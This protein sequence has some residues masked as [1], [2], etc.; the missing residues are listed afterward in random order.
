M[1]SDHNPSHFALRSLR[2]IAATTFMVTVMS[3]CPLYALGEASPMLVTGSGVLAGDGFGQALAVDGDWM[4]VGAPWHD[5]VGTDAGGVWVFQRQGQAWQEFGSLLPAAGSTRA[6]FGVSVAVSDGSLAVGAWGDSA[7]GSESGAVYTYAWD[8]STWASQG[9][10]RPNVPLAQER[11]GTSVSLSGD[12][13]AVGAY[14]ASDQ[15]PS[16]GA[17]Y[18]FACDGG[19]WQEQIRLASPTGVKG[20]YFGRSVAIDGG[21]LAVG[22]YGQDSPTAVNAGA[23]HVYAQDGG[24]WSATP[25]ASFVG[26]AAGD[27]LG[28]AV[29]VDGDT[30]LVSAPKAGVGGVAQVYEHDAGVWSLQSVLT[31]PAPVEGDLF[32]ES[33]AL[34][35][36]DAIIGDPGR[37]P[38]GAAYAFTRASGAWQEAGTFAAGTSPDEQLA[39][40]AVAIQDGL[41]VAGAPGKSSGLFSGAVYAFAAGTKTAW[42]GPPGTASPWSNANNWSAGVPSSA[43][44][45]AVAGPDAD[46]EASA[47][48]ITAGVLAIGMSGQAQLKL[49][50]AQAE[51]GQLRIGP[52]GVVCA[53]A[54]STITLSGGLSNAGSS[55]NSLDIS[56]ATVCWNAPGQQHATLEV[57]GQ[58]LG[59][60]EAGW[61]ENASIGHLII[62][63]DSLLNLTD[64]FDNARGASPEALYIGELTIEPGGRIALA[65]LNLYYRNGGVPLRLVP[66]DSD[67]DGDVDW[68]DLQTLATNFGLQGGGW[69]AGDYDG[70]GVVGASDYMAVKLHM[71]TTQPVQSNLVPEPETFILLAALVMAGGVVRR[72][73]PRHGGIRIGVTHKS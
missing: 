17:A 11:F 8:G 37:G 60:D 58:D 38:N 48:S 25:A 30:L 10:L 62:S 12:R 43:T 33:V 16:S 63:A 26:S 56:A 52:G 65:G 3:A 55:P 7:G 49:Q 34:D 40:S 64:L 13:L 72:N 69:Q 21:V 42:Q 45:A 29:A 35:G 6:G 70:D 27:E 9:V 32:G 22:A 61:A 23:V 41:A 18:V 73:R 67:L 59:P 71:G 50:D 1:G 66:G 36:D 19:Q 44:S 47:E 4:V 20:D 2:L 51:F 54:G 57:A 46:V 68:D 39:G 14:G 53:D 5:A 28:R 15:A 24:Q 31:S